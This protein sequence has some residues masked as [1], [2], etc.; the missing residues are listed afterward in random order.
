MK[1]IV[2]FHLFNDYSGS[3][4]VLRTVVEGLLEKGYNIDLVTSR[5]GVLDELAGKVGL[6]MR[7][8]NY[9]FARNKFIRCMRYA[10]VQLQVFFIAL[11]Y[12]FK[13][14]TI[15]Y[16]NT[17]LPVGAAIGGRLACKKVV[18][19]YHENAKAKSTAYRILAKIMQLIA[20]EIICVSQYQRSFLR[21]R[22]GVHIVPNALQESFT[23]RLTP[24]GER[25]LENRRVLM[26][27]SLKEYKGTR[28]FI[29]LAGRQPQYMFELVIND[30]Q[31]NIDRYLREK[32]I[33]P[34]GN[35]AIYPRQED[36]TPFYN[37][38]SLVLNLSNRKQFVETFGLTALEAMTAGLPTIVPTVGGIAEM[39]AN[40]ENGYRIDVQDIEKI[41]Q[42]IENTLAD[43]QLYMRLA[44]CALQ[45]SKSYS[46]E[47]MTAAI[48]KIIA[49]SA[50]HQHILLISYILPPSIIFPLCC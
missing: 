11:S 2:C 34:T 4:Q 44:N 48:E 40:G 28:E 16:I 14:D 45:R 29:A 12:I 1:N 33:T 15:I 3:P 39:I 26:L 31:E 46:A 32:K 20:S 41:E 19:H 30:S 38:A 37:R 23:A 10:W 9:R 8:Y 5:G 13:K 42:C 36:V 25:A 21:R 49:S 7:Q 43:K 18:Y 22:K 47:A 27:G 35:L 17:I 6:R 50:G 24:D